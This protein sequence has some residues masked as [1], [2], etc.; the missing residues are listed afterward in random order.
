MRLFVGIPLSSEASIAL[1]AVCRRLHSGGDG[2]RWTHRDSWHV[3]LQFLGATREDAY[4]CVVSRLAEV[5]ST[6]VA[7]R[8][9]APGVFEHAG[10]FFAGV[11]PA[12]ELVKLRRR[13]EEATGPC[14]FLPEDRP[15]QPHI[16]LA[17]SKGVQGRRSM[18]RLRESL[19]DSSTASAVFSGVEFVAEEFLLYESFTRPEGSR[20]EVRRRYVLERNSSVY[21]DPR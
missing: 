9:Q 11:S 12:P 3:T 16:T 14:G 4:E 19:S 7:I 15:Y 20:Y 17:R 10:I 18:Q 21:K 6:G 1:E 5:R 13:V 8:I 2:L